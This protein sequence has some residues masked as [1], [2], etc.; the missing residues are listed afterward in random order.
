MLHRSLWS[1]TLLGAFPVP[2]AT[3]LPPVANGPPSATATGQGGFGTIKG[4]LVWRGDDVPQPK[5]LVARGRS[6]KDPAVCAADEPILDRSL[7][8]DPKTKGVRYGVVYLARPSGENPGMVK[9]L[10]EKTA[11]VTVRNCEFVPY[12]SAFHQDQAVWFTSLDPVTHNARLGPLQRPVV[13]HVLGP[14]GTFEAKLRAD[15][16]AIPLVC[17]IHGWTKGWVMV[18]D[19]PFFAVTGEDG[20]FEIAGVPAGNRALAVWQETM[21]RGGSG[22]VGRQDVP[23]RVGRVTD[24]GEIALNEGR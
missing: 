2:T 17:D 9:A 22:P 7:M 1:L 23:V 19:H 12:V 24:V 5:V 16:R 11:V 6:N 10:T 14:F 4:R 21:D 20:A 8:V 15:R 13:N 3:A 18:F